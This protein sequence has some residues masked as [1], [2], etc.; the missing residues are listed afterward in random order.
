[1]SGINL[2]RV[3]L[4]GLLAGLFVNITESFFNMVLM[5]KPFEAAMQALHLPPMSMGV[6][7][8]FI[9]WGFIQGFLSVWFYAAIRPRYGAGPATAIRVGLVVWVLAYLMPDLSNALLHIMPMKPILMGAAWSLV[10]A[11]LTVMVGAWL[12]QEA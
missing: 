3:L 6:L 1:M 2:K 4:G 9:A 10:E 11:P 8:F 5:A 7:G 12:Y